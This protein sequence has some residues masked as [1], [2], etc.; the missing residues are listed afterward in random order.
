VAANTRIKP[1]A[2][3]AIVHSGVAGAPD[4]LAV[5]LTDG[6]GNLL[7][8]TDN[9][10]GTATLSSTVSVSVEPAAD[11]VSVG[12]NATA[13]IAVTAKDY[14]GFTIRETAGAAAV[15]RIWDNDDAASGT[16]LDEIGLAPLESAR[17]YYPDGGVKTTVGIYL[18][19]VSGTVVGSVRT[20]A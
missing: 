8:S 3:G 5:A 13:A 14:R 12:F 16:V 4:V 15:V 10:D 17:E 7:K 11:T 19:V 18:Q 6:A 9:G 1:T 2:S 20:G